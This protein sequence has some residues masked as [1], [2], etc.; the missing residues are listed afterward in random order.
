MQCYNHPQRGA[1]SL[2]AYCGKAIC[3]ECS[4]DVEGKTYCQD[5][6]SRGL[7]PQR[8]ELPHE[9]TNPLA[10]V[11]LILGILGLCGGLPFAAGAWIVGG[12]AIAQIEQGS[13][14]QGGLELARIGRGLGIAATAL[15][16]AI[17]LCSLVLYSLGLLGSVLQQ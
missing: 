10:I 7:L 9:P 15:Y 8:R 11:S 17:L 6:L 4:V 5:C 3:S 16:G 2:C 12:K 1:V 14:K 13:T